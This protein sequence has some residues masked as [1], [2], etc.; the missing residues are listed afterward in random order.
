MDA[1]AACESDAALEAA[2]GRRAYEILRFILLS[3]RATLV[4]LPDRL[5]IGPGDAVKQSVQLLCVNAAPEREVA[6]QATARGPSVWL[7]HGSTVSR[8]HS[9]LHTGLRDL[10]ETADGTHAG[11]TTFG[12]GVYQSESSTVSV[13]YAMSETQ[14]LGAQNKTC[15][16]NSKF[17]NQLLVMALCENAPGKQLNKVAPFE[18]TQRDKDGLIVRC[19]FIVKNQFAWDVI[20]QPPRAVPTLRDCVRCFAE[21]LTGQTDE[22][23][24]PLA[25]GASTSTLG[26]Q[27]WRHGKR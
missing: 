27:R 1:L 3:N 17:G 15:Y 23:E 11:A 20:A 16:T 10:G 25:P 26:K 24:P 6:F 18:W 8:W 19:L 2:I 9:I 7:W 22:G 13:Q 5:K 14:H 21:R 12:Q 4:C